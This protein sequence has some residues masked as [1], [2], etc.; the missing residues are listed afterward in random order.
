MIYALPVVALVIGAAAVFGAVGWNKSKTNGT[1]PGPSSTIVV[2][3][4]NATTTST[5]GTTLPPPSAI[6][7]APPTVA[8]SAD[9]SAKLAVAPSAKATVSN[10]KPPRPPNDPNVGTPPTSTSVLDTKI[11]Q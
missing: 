8:P 9:P 1:N 10:G 7:S 11:K 4:D 5:L 2:A 3:P 6:P